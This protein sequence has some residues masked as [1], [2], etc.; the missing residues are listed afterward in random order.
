[1]VS[2][3][4]LRKKGD[5]IKIVHYVLVCLLKYKF[6]KS[7]AVYFKRVRNCYLASTYVET[8]IFSKCEYKWFFIIEKMLD[9]ITAHIL[10]PYSKLW[11]AIFCY[12]ADKLWSKKNL[13]YIIN[14]EPTLCLLTET[15]FLIRLTLGNQQ[16]CSHQD[17]S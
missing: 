6:S 7:H 12:Y 9:I 1:M 5:K 3:Y 4:T 17:Q 10:L 2:R 14:T 16:L 15:Y 13:F 11:L 8:R